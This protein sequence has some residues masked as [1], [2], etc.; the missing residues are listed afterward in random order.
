MSPY[1]KKEL[2]GFRKYTEL[3]ITV[4]DKVDKIQLNFDYQ[5]TIEQHQLSF[6]DWMD[7]MGVTKLMS[8]VDWKM[9]ESEVLKELTKAGHR[10]YFLQTWMTDYRDIGLNFDAWYQY[11][12]KTLKPPRQISL[13]QGTYPDMTGMPPLQD[14]TQ[15]YEK[16]QRKT[17]CNLQAPPPEDPPKNKKQ[18]H[19][20]G[21]KMW[22]KSHSHKKRRKPSKTHTTPPNQQS[23]RQTEISSQKNNDRNFTSNTIKT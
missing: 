4:E 15:H 18:Y 5:R 13:K 11:V 10:D 16:V 20:H 1:C 21:S 12:G 3:P 14:H 9:D 6:T 8:R 22:N 17:V 19:S 23:C 2:T 7:K